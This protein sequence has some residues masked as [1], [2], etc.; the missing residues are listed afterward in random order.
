MHNKFL[1]LDYIV[2]KKSSYALRM[3]MSG[4]GLH[5][6]S[7][8]ICTTYPIIIFV[9]EERLTMSCENNKVMDNQKLHRFNCF[10][11]KLQILMIKTIFAKTASV[12]LG[13]KPP[14][15]FTDISKAVLL[16]WFIFICYHIYNV[17]LLH[18]FVATIRL[19]ALPSALY[20]ILS[21]LAL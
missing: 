7:T 18:D 15:N 19:S 21:K 1:K 16:L 6:F 2:H 14:S 17:C 9:H 4:T 8:Y 11:Y 13:F 3:I 20:F 5:S 12:D 10:L